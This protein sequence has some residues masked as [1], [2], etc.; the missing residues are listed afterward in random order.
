MNLN[1]QLILILAAVISLGLS[2][3][4]FADTSTAW[5]DATAGELSY[6]GK[7]GIGT[8][9]PDTK[10]HVN[11]RVLIGGEDVF[12]GGK[13]LEVYGNVAGTEGNGYPRAM[14][15]NPTLTS[16]PTNNF[17]AAS[18]KV[19]VTGNVSNPITTLH[20]NDIDQYASTGSV[21]RAIG[22]HISEQTYATDNTNLYIKS[23]TGMAGAPPG[24]FSI[25][26]ASTRNNYIAGKVGIG[27]TDP[28]TAKL[29]VFGNIVATGT[30]TTGCSR[31]LKKD[32]V[33]ISHTEAE[34]ALM[35]LD[36]VSFRYKANDAELNIGFIAEDV[37]D[38]VATNDRKGLNSMDLVTLAI[39]VIQ[40]QQDRIEQLEKTVADLSNNKI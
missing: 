11:G 15:F 3:G 29:K 24:D 12:S 28:G 5:N 6:S 30:V 17:A 23:G 1:K 22:L 27:T 21:T 39:T 13:L 18:L 31:T 25:Y 36:P 9:S 7:V 16:N 26:N 2:Q 20:V 8:T 19:I 32:I 35:A 10:F 40:E 38:M 37:P 4:A 33:S 14:Y 34:Q